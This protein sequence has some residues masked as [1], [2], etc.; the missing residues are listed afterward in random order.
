MGASRSSRA[1]R[2]EA[3]E[4]VLPRALG[5]RSSQVSLFASTL[6]LAGSLVDP[7]LSLL[8]VTSWNEWNEDTQI[9]PTALGPPP[10]TGPAELT[11]G[12]AYQPYGLALLE[13]LRRFTDGWRAPA[14]HRVRAP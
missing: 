5:P 12:Y 13:L 11:Q 6:A 1:I 14:A 2:S 3:D 8:A 4:H 10:A 7:S 9:E